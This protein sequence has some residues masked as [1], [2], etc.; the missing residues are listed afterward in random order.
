MENLG[1]LAVRLKRLESQ[2]ALVRFLRVVIALR[3]EV[4]EGVETED[5]VAEGF[6]ERVARCVARGERP[7]LDE[8]VLNKINYAKYAETL[9]RFLEELKSAG[10][11][12]G[13]LTYLID[14]LSSQP[15]FS[16]NLLRSVLLGEKMPEQLST[17]SFDILRVIALAPLHK[18]LKAVNKLNSKLD[19]TVFIKGCLTCG[20]SY[21]LAVYKGGFKHVVCAACGNVARVD[22]FYCPN[23]GSTDPKTMRFLAF[24]EEPFLQ[25]DVCD[26]CNTYRK[27]IIQDVIGV[28]VDDHLLLDAVTKDLDA[29]AADLLKTA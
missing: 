19:T 14:S 11:G 12:N 23:C 16:K 18:V 3:N 2:Y 25:L 26:R 15:D 4:L 6:N 8:E 22:F 29:L 28:E 9:V 17:V 10:L 1:V 27:V 21:S 13:V 24:Q 7:F 20:A 5:L